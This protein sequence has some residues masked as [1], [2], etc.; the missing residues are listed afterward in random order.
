MKEISSIKYCCQ[1]NLAKSQVLWTLH[2]QLDQIWENWNFFN[3]NLLKL[4]FCNKSSQNKF[5]FSKPADPPFSWKRLI[6][7]EN[8]RKLHKTGL[9]VK[10]DSFQSV[11]CWNEQVA[12]FR[13]TETDLLQNWLNLINL[14]LNLI[15]LIKLKQRHQNLCWGYAIY[16]S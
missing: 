1:V 8:E 6:P 16:S 14:L 12:C 7:S 13:Q 10:F 2:D 15:N 3:Q 5:I 11:N 4:K 9:E